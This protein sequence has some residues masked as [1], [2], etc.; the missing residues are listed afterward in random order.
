MCPW[1]F[2]CSW[3]THHGRE[4]TIK[5]LGQGV[6]QSGLAALWVVSALSLQAL[7]Q[8][9]GEHLLGIPGA[10]PASGKSYQL[11]EEGAILGWDRSVPGLTVCLGSLL[12]QAGQQGMAHSEKHCSEQLRKTRHTMVLVCK[13]P[14][15]WIPGAWAPLPVKSFTLPIRVPW[16][17]KSR[18][19]LWG[20]GNEQTWDSRSWSR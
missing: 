5:A 4:F 9:L 15:P 19:G 12:C 20:V 1:R 8:R 13:L 3:G 10:S 6:T 18:E 17:F 7:K 11:A 14:S 16:P 2:Q